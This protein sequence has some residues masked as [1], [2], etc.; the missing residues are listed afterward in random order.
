[1]S[2]VH[3]LA[4]RGCL[5]AWKPGGDILPLVALVLLCVSQVF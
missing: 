2:A 1:M 4:M 5:E 3:I